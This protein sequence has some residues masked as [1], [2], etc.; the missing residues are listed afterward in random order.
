[1]GTLAGQS[2]P[3]PQ[4]PLTHCPVLCHFNEDWVTE[5]HTYASQNGIWAVLLQRDIS[6]RA[7]VVAYASR[8][9]SDHSNELECLAVVWS[10]DENF[11]HYLFGRQ[12]TVV[13]DNSATAWMF[14]K[15]Y[16]KHKFARWIA[17]LQDYTYDVCHRAGAQDQLGDE[18]STISFASHP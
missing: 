1:M 12:F 11:S 14:Q 8:K 4:T 15:Q 17:R 7:H 18:P 16:L 13:T 10:V 2:L 5:L 9:L 6:G 3:K